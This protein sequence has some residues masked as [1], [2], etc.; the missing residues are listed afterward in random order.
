MI[1]RIAINGT[2][3]IFSRRDHLGVILGILSVCGTRLN[4]TIPWVIC[5]ICLFALGDHRRVDKMKR[6]SIATLVSLLIVSTAPAADLSCARVQNQGKT[7]MKLTGLVVQSTRGER[8]RPYM[9]L[10]LRAPACLARPHD[11]QIEGPEAITFIHVFPDEQVE[12]YLGHIVTINGRF[13]KDPENTL[14]VWDAKILD[15]TDVGQTFGP[16]DGRP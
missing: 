13:G 11:P 15:L 4:V 14:F 3:S 16:N 1:A 2:M 12:P 7:V 10:A 5:K 9:A 6:F 8:L